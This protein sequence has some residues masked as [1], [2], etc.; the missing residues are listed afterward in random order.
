MVVKRRKQTENKFAQRVRSV[1][2]VREGEKENKQISIIYLCFP[3]H[4]LRWH[5]PYFSALHMKT[6]SQPLPLY[7]IVSFWAPLTDKYAKVTRLIKEGNEGEMSLLLWVN[8][9]WW[10]ATWRTRLPSI[11]PICIWHWKGK[12]RGGWRGAGWSKPQGEK[13]GLVPSSNLPLHNF[14]AVDS[15]SLFCVIYKVGRSAPHT[16]SSSSRSLTLRKENNK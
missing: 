16:C 13:L 7:I 2:I 9:P 14:T 3:S 1:I 15:M 8:T 11:L 12:K 4:F 5:I 6:G 10:C